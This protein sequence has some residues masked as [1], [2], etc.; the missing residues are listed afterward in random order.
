LILSGFHEAALM[1]QGANRIV[2][3]DKKVVFQYTTSSSSL[4]RKLGVR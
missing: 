1:A 3:P 2:Y 4:Q